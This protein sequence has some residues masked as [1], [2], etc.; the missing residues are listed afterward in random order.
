MAKSQWQGSR[1]CVKR[2]HGGGGEAPFVV[3][4]D[5]R[6]SRLDT[7]DPERALLYLE[8]EWSST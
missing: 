4:A 2:S 8:A 7:S 5:R 3:E 1:P 6:D